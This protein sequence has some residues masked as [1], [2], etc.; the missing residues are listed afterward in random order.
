MRKLLCLLVVLGILML[1][2]E[3][4]QAVSSTSPIAVTAKIQA[5]TPDMDV[6]VYKIPNGDSS[7]I[8]WAAPV[9]SM[10][11]EKFNVVQRTGKDPQWTSVDHF[12]AFVY[13]NGMGKKYQIKS[14]G[15]GSFT[16]GSNTLPAGSF[17]C[18]PVYSAADKWKY[19]DETM[20]AQGNMPSS[21][22][23]G[24]K[25]KAIA[26]DKQVYTSENPGTAR[27]IQVHYAFPPYN[28]DGTA[29]YTTDYAPIPA[30]QA[31]GTY[32]GVTV[33]LSIAAI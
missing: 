22:S 1:F 21:A 23:L 30:T 25:G 7:L 6:K 8:D 19:P 12:V 11:F 14:T 13:A 31:T 16:S 4:A 5:G 28:I 26:T 29:P 3:S 27:I 9:G 24:S 32:S 20:V 18:I 2:A 33:T 10:A 15:S 17:A